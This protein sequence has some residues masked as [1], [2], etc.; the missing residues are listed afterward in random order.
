[1]LGVTERSMRVI[2]RIGEISGSAQ[3]GEAL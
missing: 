2:P 3:E 1:M